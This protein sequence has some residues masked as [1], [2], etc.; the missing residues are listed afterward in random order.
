LWLRDLDVLALAIMAATVFVRAIA[1]LLFAAFIGFSQASRWQ[2]GETLRQWL[3]IGLL[4]PGFYLGG[5]RGAVLGVL[6]SEL[7][8][9]A[10][11]FH[12]LRP[13]LPWPG[14]HLNV[15]RSLPYLQFG[16]IFFAADA[17]GTALGASGEALVR[18]VTGD[19][20]QSG[21][22]GL[23]WRVFMTAALAI[24]FLTMAFLPLLTTLRAQ[25]QVEALRRWVERLLKYLLLGGVAASFGALLLA[26]A[27]VPLVLGAQYGAVA[28]SLVWLTF[29]LLPLAVGQV[30]RVVAALY[31]RPRAALVA[32]AL[33]LLAFWIVGVLFTPRLGSLGSSVAMLV[34]RTLYALYLTWRMRSVLRYS[35]RE[36]AMVLGL[37][38]L[39]LPLS[40]LRSSWVIN[41]ALYAACLVGYFVMLL[42][43]QVVTRSEVAELWQALTVRARIPEVVSSEE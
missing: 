6:L 12:W 11:G 27:L 29:T 9:L 2:V 33:Q 35:L 3:S 31:L 24:P 21:F 18:A 20:A 36:G 4:L 13:R 23:A 19:Y 32:S 17:L 22:F 42:I 1:D 41:V 28:S 38:A 15:H 26:D 30:A 7:G 16:V 40:L 14:L 43:T 37:G 5:L 25:G 10:L 39:F 34:T 8:V